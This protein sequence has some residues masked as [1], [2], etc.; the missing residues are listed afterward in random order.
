MSEKIVYWHRDLPPL[1][2]DPI[3]EHVLE[4]TSCRVPGTIS[5]RDDLW[6]VCYEDL[7]RQAC[8]R[9]EQEATRLG[10]DYAHVAHEVID[11]RHDPATGEAWLRGRFDYVL[12]RRTA[13]RTATPTANDA[14]GNLVHKSE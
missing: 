3:G 2:A 7:M 10:G 1:D 9:I 8:G 4:A 14:G 6:R 13:K 12:Y 11:S 5:H